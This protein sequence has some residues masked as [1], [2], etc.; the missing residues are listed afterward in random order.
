RQTLG[1]PRHGSSTHQLPAISRRDVMS[2]DNGSRQTAV[3]GDERPVTAAPG[4]YISDQPA[5]VAPEPASKDESRNGKGRRLT[6]TARKKI[7]AASLG[8]VL[9]L[10]VAGYFIR[11][12]FF[13]E[14][15]DDAQVQGHIMPLSARVN[16]Q[17]LEVRVVEGQ[18][19][20]AGDVLVVIDPR[21]YKIAA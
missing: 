1:G 9:I 11:N 10:L 20:H 4:P 2:N 21:D 18:F 14:G 13:Y 17:I 16:G 19:V 8:S 15:T 3:L 12:A 7:F 6:L 5:V